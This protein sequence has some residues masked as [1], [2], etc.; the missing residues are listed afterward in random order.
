MHQITKSDYIPVPSIKSKAIMFW[1]SSVCGPVMF[2]CFFLFL[3][4]FSW[5][6]YGL[7]FKFLSKPR[8]LVI[9]KQLRHTMIDGIPEINVA[10]CILI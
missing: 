10:L 9:N 3:L 7:N 1:I 4:L 5:K 6:M 8:P 2:V